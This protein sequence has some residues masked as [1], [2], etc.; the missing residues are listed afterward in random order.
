MSQGQPKFSVFACLTGR[1]FMKVAGRYATLAEA[2][3]RIAEL[4]EDYDTDLRYGTEQHMYEVVGREGKC[5]QTQGSRLCGKPGTHLMPPVWHDGKFHV[6]CAE[7]AAVYDRRWGH[8]ET[9]AMY[10]GTSGNCIPVSGM[11]Q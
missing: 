10:D 9:K 3:T 11:K 5:V 2:V 1:P 4:G 8:G 7:H 6:F